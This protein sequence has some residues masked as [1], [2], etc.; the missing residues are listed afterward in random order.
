I[1]IVFVLIGASARVIAGVQNASPPKSMLKV[2]VIG[3]Q[4]WWS[5][6]YPDYGIVTAN[7]IHVPVAVAG[8][9]ATYLQLESQD[10]IHSF[11]VPQLA[12]KFDLIPNRTNYMWL[13]PQQPGVYFGNCAEYCGTQHANMLIRLVAQPKAE[14][15][16]W[17]AAE[18]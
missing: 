4:W 13:D 15:D 12:G 9:S 6:E 5:D 2:K 10:V 7:E 17:A 8:E 1:L 16:R 3:H 11:W 18:R 14:F